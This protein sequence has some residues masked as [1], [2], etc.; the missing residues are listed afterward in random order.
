MLHFS[1]NRRARPAR[2]KSAAR[3]LDLG[4]VDRRPAVRKFGF[5]DIFRTAHQQAEETM[6]NPPPS[7]AFRRF[8]APMAHPRRLATVAARMDPSWPSASGARLTLLV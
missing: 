2:A 6:M 8:F 4:G 1:I 3:K 5:A 7:A